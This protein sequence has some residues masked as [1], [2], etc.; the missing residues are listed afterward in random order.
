MKKHSLKS[1]LLAGVAL[2]AFSQCTKDQKEETMTDQPVAFDVNDMDSSHKPCENFYAY[3]IGNWQKENPVP[4]TESRWMSFN[5]LG[6]ANKAK[7]QIILDETAEKKD[8]VKGSSAQ[9]IRDYYL[10]V[11][12]T[13]GTAELGMQPIHHLFDLINSI[14]KTE[15][16]S[17]ILGKLKPLGVGG[18]IGIHVGVD[19]KNSNTHLT[20]ASQTG[21]SLPDRDYYLG[22]DDKMV[23]FREKYVE[24]V[25]AMFEIAEMGDSNMGQRIL[26]LETKIAEI[27]W[28]K[29]ELRVAEKTYNKFQLEDWVSGFEN[30]DIMAYLNGAGFPEFTEINVSQPSFYEGI[31]QMFADVA[32]EEWKHWLRWKTIQSYGSGINADFEKESFGFWSTTLRGVQ[33]MKSRQERALRRVNGALGEPLG[34][35]FVEKHF[36]EES[37]AY[38]SEMIENLRSAYRESIQNLE[39]M[40]DSTKEKALKKLASFTYKIGYPDK[41]EDYSSL[42]INPDTYIAN[43]MSIRIFKYK[44]MLEKINEPVDK[45]DWHM[46]P[47]T[48]NAYYS[49]V[50]NE[51]VFPAGILQPPFFH[52]SFDDAI[53]YGGIGAVIGH[54]FTHGFDDQGSKYDWNGNLNNWW[55]DEDRAR[56]DSLS[57]KLVD[58]YNAVEVL[59]G[60]FINGKMT[61]GENIADHGG[62]T[63]AFAALK[64]QMGDSPQEPIDSLTWEQR[65]FLGWANVWKGNSTEKD[66][67]NRLII[68][69][70]S[71]AEYRVRV[72]MTNIEEFYTAFGCEKGE[73][74]PVKIW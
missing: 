47:Q 8:A 71:P 39:W 37:K 15:D 72:P 4:S 69:Y 63:L 38:V 31:D 3:S 12:D 66:I 25:N 28:P 13:N 61:L 57:A 48:V 54:E 30:L 26:Q 29:Q 60:K 16:M 35:L 6:E 65:F 32:V 74:E 7:L 52:S 64:K 20:S 24:H 49:S 51:V 42:D 1:V 27:C 59:P 36:P 11:L 19:R 9:I 46:S 22:A 53:N 45:T 23:N 73:H 62:L 67:L 5:I 34:K 43:I 18:P 41:W 58:Q 56:F 17:G 2:L 33:K 40:G 14:Q 55:T 10:S 44:L 70:H 21:M 50:G 68:D